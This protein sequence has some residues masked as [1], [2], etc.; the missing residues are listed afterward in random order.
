MELN[1]MNGIIKL[2]LCQKDCCPTVEFDNDSVIIK[3]DNGGEVSLTPAQFR[4][5]LNQYLYIQGES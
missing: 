5:L 2:T 1:R 3:D 4:I